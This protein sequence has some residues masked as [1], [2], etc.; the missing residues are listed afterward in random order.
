LVGGKR[1]IAYVDGFNFYYGA[2]REEPALKWLDFEALCAQLLRG[3]DLQ[4]VRYYTAR[5]SDRRDDPGVSQRQDVFLR[6]LATRPKME[7]VYGKFRTRTKR[8]PRAR[9]RGRRRSTVEVLVT[10]EK[11]SDVNLATDLL[12]DAAHREME[13]AL[14]VSNDF[15]LQRPVER[16]MALGIR[17]LTV[18]PHRHAGQRPSLRGSDTRNLRMS[19]LRSC[20]MPDVVVDVDGRRIR[21]PQ[22]WA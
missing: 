14:V 11:G 8:L 20:Q 18:N 22:E 9:P 17:V 5:V 10:E 4:A 16:A 12:W 21:R 3:H 19:H 13:V 1:A 15:D 6:A 7:I 2:V